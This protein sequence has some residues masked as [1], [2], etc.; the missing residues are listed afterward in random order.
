MVNQAG[1]AEV[2]I[3]GF[4]NHWRGQIDAFGD[5]M[6]VQPHRFLGL[7]KVLVTV[8]VKGKADKIRIRFSP[9]L[10]SMLYVD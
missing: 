10:E 3:E 2:R 1:E 9:E 8:D 5:R 4:W 7:E 6:S